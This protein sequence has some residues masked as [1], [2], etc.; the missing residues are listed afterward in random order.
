MIG[1]RCCGD[2]EIGLEGEFLVKEYVVVSDV[3]RES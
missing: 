2:F 3:S 1:W